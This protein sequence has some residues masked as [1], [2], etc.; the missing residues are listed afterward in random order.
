M[1]NSAKEKKIKQIKHNA[2]NNM[3]LKKKSKN[4][5]HY[6]KFISFWHWENVWENESIVYP[7]LFF[8]LIIIIFI[9]C[10]GLFTYDLMDKKRINLI[11]FNNNAQLTYISN[12]SVKHIIIKVFYLNVAHT[13]YN[14][15]FNWFESEHYSSTPA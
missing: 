11:F 4:H 5:S 9:F 15:S 13:L 2:S 12:E 1:P 8:I 3:S 6:T 10:V 7:N 14:I